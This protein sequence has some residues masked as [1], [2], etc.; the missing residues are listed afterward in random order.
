MA[1]LAA[2]AGAVGA[3]LLLLARNRLM[4]L[5]GLALLALA[6]AGLVADLSDQGI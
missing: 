3:A 4:L 6:E 5:G 1:Q 2:V